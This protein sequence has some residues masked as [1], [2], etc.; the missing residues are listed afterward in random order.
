MRFARSVNRRRDHEK[1][2]VNVDD[3]GASFEEEVGNL[4]FGVRGPG[5]ATN[6]GQPLRGGEIFDFVV[7]AAVGEYFMAGGFE[8][9]LLLLENNFFA[10]RNLVA[11]MYKQDFQWVPCLPRRN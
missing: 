3:V 1:C 6:Q 10:A 8:Q 9:L 4:A 2:V 7:A 5:G 11:I